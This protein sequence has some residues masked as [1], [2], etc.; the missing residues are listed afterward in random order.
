MEKLDILVRDLNKRGLR[1]IALVDNLILC[2]WDEDGSYV[3]WRFFITDERLHL[4]Y[5][6]YTRKDVHTLADA[7]HNFLN[8]VRE[9]GLC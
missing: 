7:K 9:A 8:R 2:D 6:H 3:S 1:L 5:G 4:V